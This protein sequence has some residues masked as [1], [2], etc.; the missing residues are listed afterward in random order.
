M[1]FA[2]FIFRTVSHRKDV[3]SLKAWA[4]CLNKQ[5]RSRVTKTHADLLAIMTPDD[6]IFAD[7]KYLPKNVDE[8]HSFLENTGR[9]AR[10]AVQSYV[11][12]KLPLLNQTLKKPRARSTQK[13]DLGNLASMTEKTEKV[14]RARS[15]T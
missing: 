3:K 2:D 9:V 5:Q 13:T 12:Q 4:P 1:D 10:A 6:K 7:R 8:R 15:V 11:D 14:L